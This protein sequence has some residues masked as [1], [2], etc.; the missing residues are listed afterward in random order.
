MQAS[1]IDDDERIAINE[2]LC[3]LLALVLLHIENLDNLDECH[4]IANLINEFATRISLII[5]FNEVADAIAEL[6]MVIKSE[7]EQRFNEIVLYSL[8]ELTEELRTWFSRLRFFYHCNNK[9][10]V[11]VFE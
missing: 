6:A 7:D 9:T 11:I 4:E 10:I 8:R 3:E 5:E 1:P 2:T